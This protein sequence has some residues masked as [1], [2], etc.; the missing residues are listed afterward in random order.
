MMFDPGF[1]GER[2]RD[3]VARR[4]IRAATLLF[5]AAMVWGL[6]VPGHRAAAQMVSGTAAVDDKAGNGVTLNF[7]ATINAAPKMPKGLSL[8]GAKIFN[9]VMEDYQIS[10]A[11]MANRAP[12]ATELPNMKDMI[13]AS[14]LLVN[15]KLNAAQQKTAAAALAQVAL[16]KFVPNP[17]DFVAI[18]KNQQALVATTANLMNAPNAGGK[19]VADATAKQSALGGA[20]TVTTKGTTVTATATVGNGIKAPMAASY[21]VNIDPTAVTWDS[22]SNHTISIDLSQV[23]LTA[24]TTG[25]G[26][27]A[28]STMS[29][30]GSY[31]NNTGDT[32][33][34]QS[35]A[36]P[37]FQ[38]NLGLFS[39][40]GSA[41]NP[42][43][44][45][46]Y[47]GFG[48]GNDPGGL[49]IT[50]SAGGSGLTGVSND[51]AALFSKQTDGS[52]GFGGAYSITVTVPGTFTTDL[53]YLDQVETSAANAVPE[54]GSMTLLAI[55]SL[56]A[57]GYRLRRR[58]NTRRPGEDPVPPLT[59]GPCFQG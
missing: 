16:T 33:L 14:T 57:V 9:P 58:R 36:L 23:R 44:N 52:F 8:A 1:R 35:N 42:N 5:V 19:E 15:Q 10:A 39:Y 13:A 47:L 20:K 6:M 21:A 29:F 34:P 41:S 38:L 37:L 27:A 49:A 22:A 32:D 59:P 3:S 45:L 25:L 30:I 12:T 28:A 26:S 43:T 55:G 31:I 51:L 48:T 24:S 2:L 54:P 53:L 18:N 56:G 40:D 17:P 4:T 11:L 50:D 7:P 46:N